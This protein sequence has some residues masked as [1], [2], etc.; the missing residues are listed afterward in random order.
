MISIFCLNQVLPGTI[1]TEGAKCHIGHSDGHTC[2]HTGIDMGRQ[3]NLWGTLHALKSLSIH[4]FELSH[5]ILVKPI[6]ASIRANF[7]WLIVDLKTKID[8]Y[9]YDDLKL[10]GLSMNYSFPSSNV[11]YGR[12]KCDQG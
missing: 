8:A 11:K 4:S 1:G 12:K 6:S 5:F 10:I 7:F 9:K 3:S 2:T